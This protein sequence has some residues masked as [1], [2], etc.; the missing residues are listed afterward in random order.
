M[1]QYN[2]YQL[3]VLYVMIKFESHIIIY[4]K[5]YQTCIIELKLA[6]YWYKVWYDIDNFLYYNVIIM[7]LYV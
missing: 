6:W 1:K 7:I 5:M 4:H 2:I 3:T